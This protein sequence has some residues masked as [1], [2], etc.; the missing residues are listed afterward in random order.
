MTSSTDPVK[1]SRLNEL[2]FELAWKTRDEIICNL[3]Q[4]TKLLSGLLIKA[5][6]REKVRKAN[7]DLVATLMNLPLK[8][9]DRLKS[10]ESLERN[11]DGL[12]EVLLDLSWEARSSIVDT[13][14]TNHQIALLEADSVASE[15]KSKLIDQNNDLIWELLKLRSR[16]VSKGNFSDRESR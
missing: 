15:C 12:N 11:P 9:D 4:H 14:M 10:F 7:V 1:T 5:D 3:S 6:V 16:T 8:V 13:L 2:E